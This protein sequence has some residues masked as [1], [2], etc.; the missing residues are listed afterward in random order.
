[1][2]F[3]GLYYADIL[4]YADQEDFIPFSE[5][6]VLIPQEPESA[7]DPIAEQPGS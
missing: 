6:E 4:V 7:Q 5:I 2:I 1:M 3:W